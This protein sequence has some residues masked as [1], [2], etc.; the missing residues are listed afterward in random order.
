MKDQGDETAMMQVD[1]QR[2]DFIV[3]GGRIT[4]SDFFLWPLYGLFALLSAIPGEPRWLEWA[5]LGI[6][7]L[8][9]LSLAMVLPQGMFRPRSWVQGARVQLPLILTSFVLGQM[10]WFAAVYR[11]FSQTSPASFSERLNLARAL[12]FSAT[13]WTT[14][15]FGDIHASSD[16]TRLLVTLELVSAL[17]TVAVVVTAAVTAAFSSKPEG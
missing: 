4:A 2:P 12:Y 16:G 1:D 11:I 6:G 10:A 14:T 15:G 7:A 8:L 5:L 3:Y 13:C 17:V 9:L